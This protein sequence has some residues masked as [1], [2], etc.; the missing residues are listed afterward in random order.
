[1]LE[2]KDFSR[3]VLSTDIR[4]IGLTTR[5]RNCLIQNDIQTVRDLVNAWQSGEIRHYRN[6]GPIVIQEITNKLL[7]LSKNTSNKTQTL[8]D[9][10]QKLEKQIAAHEQ[11][12]QRLK[13][14]LKLLDQ[15]NNKQ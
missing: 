10:R 8:H 4:Q 5:T 11:E 13:Q 9:A 1:M 7:N 15:G 2:I 14:Q 3:Q 6:V 12:S